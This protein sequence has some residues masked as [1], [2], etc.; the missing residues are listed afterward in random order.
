L[1][2]KYD[3]HNY[4]NQHI[5]AR[6]AVAK[7]PISERN[8]EIVLDFEKHLTVT[9]ISVPRIVRYLFCLKKVAIQ[10]GKDFDKATKDDITDIIYRIQQSNYTEWTK[11][12]YKCILKRFYKWLKG[13]D[14]SYPEEVAWIR[15]SV[16]RNKRPLPKKEDL[17]TEEDMR[18]LLAKTTNVRDR[19]LVAILW[20]SGA[21]IGEIG[22]Q[23][24]GFVS[25]DKYGAVVMVDGKTGPRNIRLIN[26]SSY[27]SAWMDIHPRRNDKHAP[28]WV[29]IG[30]NQGEHIHYR[31]ITKILGKLFARAGIDKR[32]NPHIFRHSRAT[33]LANYLTE[34]QMNQYLG[35]VQGS[36]MPSTYVHLSGKDTDKALLNLYGLEAGEDL[37]DKVQKPIVCKRCDT[38]NPA[39]SKFCSKCGGI[40]DIK[41]AFEIEEQKA[42]RDKSDDIMNKLLDDPVL[43]EL[44]VKKLK[45]LAA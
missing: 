35:W 39:E 14:E 13:N 37:K 43:K 33:F 17:L 44:F 24:I 42:V 34:F 21:R 15:T 22:N 45:E 16:P 10:L 12:T 18:K 23:E 2:M 19:A 36:D 28:L 8:K 3:I 9:G 1:R 7:A 38:I 11:K 5:Y 40:M 6:E 41:T 32:Y 25:F 30:S 29:C 27:L 31:G 20:E 4:A 26:S